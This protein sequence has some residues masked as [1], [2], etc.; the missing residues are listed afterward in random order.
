M[1]T[2]EELKV[3]LEAIRSIGSG[4]FSGKVL[5]VGEKEFDAVALELNT[6]ATALS[7]RDEQTKDFISRAVHQIR[8]PIASIRWYLEMILE[9]DLRK[10][11]EEQKNRTQKV[12]DSVLSLINLIDKLLIVDHIQSSRVSVALM[13]VDVKKMLEAVLAQCANLIKNNPQRIAVVSDEGAA[14]QVQADSELLWQ[15]VTNLITNALKY[16]DEKSTVTVN[17]TGDN[18]SI[19]LAVSDAGIGIPKDEQQA[20]TTKFF[21]ATNARKYHSEG[22]GLGLYIASSFIAKMGGKLWF[23]SSEG[24]GT[25]FYISLPRAS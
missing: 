5:P 20:I 25:T 15:V 22:S 13:K 17:L 8:T 3:L 2:D 19:T 10:F 16:S 12:Y 9:G 7:A 4:D 1:M 11:T 24:K 6:A 18:S 23:E 21:R 14:F